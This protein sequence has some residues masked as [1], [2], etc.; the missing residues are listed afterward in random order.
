M[1]LGVV[2]IALVGIVGIVGQVPPAP[3]EPAPRAAPS[4]RMAVPPPFVPGAGAAGENRS[5]RN[6]TNFPPAYTAGG[7]QFLVQPGQDW[8]HIRRELQPGDEVIFPAGFHLPQKI[9]GLAGTREKP[10]VLRSR[11]TIAGAVSCADFGWEFVQC[12]H[13]LVENMLFLN[14]TE[15]AIVVDGGGAPGQ[16]PG[17]RFRADVVV[18]NCTVQGT[19]ESASQDGVRVRA[20]ADVTL[21]ALRVEGWQDA[22]VEVEDVSR[23]LVRG[24]MTVPARGKP[25]ARGVAMLG[26]SSEVV[27]TGAAFNREIGVGVQVGSAGKDAWPVERSAVERCLFDGPGVAVRIANAREFTFGR[28]TIYE[29]TKAVY[30][31]PADAGIVTKV[32]IDKMLVTWT[33]GALERF[34]P[35]PEGFAVDSITLG[36]NL[37]FSAEL[38]TAWTVLGAPVGYRRGTQVSDVDP[39]LEPRTLRPKNPDAKGYGVFAGVAVAP[40]AGG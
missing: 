17:E 23:V 4:D 29:P 24:L 27:V 14:P 40:A 26:R 28:A 22:A 19:K 25:A 32:T 18:R 35:V 33:P 31:V 16:A 11:D 2:S 6:G 9:E 38:P 1:M 34:S 15:A 30:E 21:D 37:W 36:D 8:A 3:A 13:L 5:G 39:T 12:K 10:I 20:A 7:R